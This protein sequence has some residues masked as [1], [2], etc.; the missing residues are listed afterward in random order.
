MVRS[1]A[2]PL[3][4]LL[5]SCA[6]PTGAPA[7][8]DDDDDAAACVDE[9]AD[10][11]CADEDC[12]DAD[13]AVY[14]GRTEV[15]CDDVDND[16]D[17][18]TP[19]GLD[20]DEDGVDA[21]DDCD[22][23][24]SL[25]AP[26]LA[27]V[28]CDDLDNDCDAETLDAPDADVDG[29]TVCAGD[30]DD[31]DPARHPEAAPTCTGT[32]DDCSGDLSAAEASG[33]GETI[34]C[35][36]EGVCQDLIDAD[37]TLASGLY[38]VGDEA[39]GAFQIECMMDGPRGWTQLEPTGSQGVYVAENS[40]SNA[41]D[42]C[43]DDSAQYFDWLTGEDEVVPDWTSG[44]TELNIPLAYRNPTSGQTYA[45]TMMEFL[46]PRLS[47]YAD[48]TRMVAVTSDDDNLD[49]D[50]GANGGHEVYVQGLDGQWLNLTPGTNGECGGS[51]NWPFANSES[52]HY[53]WHPNPGFC[54][55]GGDTGGWQ[56]LGGTGLGANWVVPTNVRLVVQ[57]GG[58]VAFGWTTRV[59]SV[60]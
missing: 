60:R 17:P 2:L 47:L 45:F 16:C 28:Q 30:C 41:W 21:C 57:T 10:G 35:P 25:V 26:G 23:D 59:I 14:P 3:A 39:S 27:E 15:S 56:F 31:D 7:P 13:P 53:R 12:D 52:A 5:T 9:D 44:N 33:P 6:L 18:E 11:A 48:A 1:L 32:D 49:W 34:D 42:K 37:P 40:A 36:F 4:L 22:D 29:W 51:N 58:G 20:V 24:E 46:R 8:D 50:G 43:A 55:A 38:W 19:D 54:E